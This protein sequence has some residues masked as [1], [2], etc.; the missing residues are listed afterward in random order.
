M[1]S[2][3]EDQVK[4]SVARSSEQ[5]AYPVPSGKGTV[6][7]PSI[8]LLYEN[9]VAVGIPRQ[10]AVDPPLKTRGAVPFVTGWRIVPAPSRKVM[11]LTCGQSREAAVR[12]QRSQEE[13]DGW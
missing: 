13:R 1:D 2:V 5:Q 3:V 11:V 12:E 6:P 10:N 9:L 8:E 7:V 4:H